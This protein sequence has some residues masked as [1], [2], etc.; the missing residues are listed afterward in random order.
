VQILRLWYRKDKEQDYFKAAKLHRKNTYLKY[1]SGQQ[2]IK[3]NL[4]HRNLNR[5][6]LYIYREFYDF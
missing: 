1:L 4:R 3:E 2:Q 5:Y 6:L